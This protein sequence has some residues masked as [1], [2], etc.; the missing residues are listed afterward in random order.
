MQSGLSWNLMLIKRENFRRAFANF[1]PEAIARFANR[2]IDR[3]MGD[4]TIIRNRRKIAAAIENARQFL[5]IQEENET[6]ARYLWDF[7]DG[8][9][10]D[11]AWQHHEDIPTTSKLSGKLSRD[12]RQRGF[13][14]VGSVTIYA[15]MEGAGLYNNHLL[16]CFRHSEVKRLGE[17][18]PY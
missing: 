17:A 16:S 10:I 14:F 4:A 12:L 9:P 6:F 3:L 1:D 7:V 2:D 18:L 13:R 15:Y 11:D 8:N 5:A